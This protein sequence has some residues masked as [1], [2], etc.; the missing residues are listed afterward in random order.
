MELLAC[1]LTIM[2]FLRL[3]VSQERESKMSLERTLAAI[4]KVP[5][6]QCPPL[7]HHLLQVQNLMEV[8]NKL[9]AKLLMATGGEEASPLEQEIR[10][11]LF[12]ELSL[13]LKILANLPT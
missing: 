6:D 7:L 1:S 8:G 3:L 5:P 11:S 10:F 4:D 12:W 9:R 13:S 2:L